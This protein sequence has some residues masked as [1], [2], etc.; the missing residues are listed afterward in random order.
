MGQSCPRTKLSR[1]KVVPAR[2]LM[3]GFAGEKVLPVGSIELSVTTGTYSR[4]R[5]IMVKLLLVD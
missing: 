2:Y 3:V 5:I 1:D 4:Q